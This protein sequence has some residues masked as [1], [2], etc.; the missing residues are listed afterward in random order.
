MGNYNFTKDLKIAKVTEEEVA[1]ILVKKYNAKISDFNDTNSHDI[2]GTIGNKT[3]TFEVKEDFQCGDTGNIAVEYS[4]RGKPSGIETTKAQYY[5]YKV[6]LK[7][8]QVYVIS[9]VDKLR[10][11]IADNQYFRVVNGGDY[12]SNSLCYLFKY[13]NFI[14]TGRVFHT[15]PLK[16]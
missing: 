4:C 10:K 15:E 9:S 1:D 3:F 5:I 16:E 2:T 11:A 7:D 8:K 13:K 14:N 6:H 12:K